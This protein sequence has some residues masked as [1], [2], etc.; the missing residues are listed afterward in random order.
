MTT[1][2]TLQATNELMRLQEDTLLLK[3]QLKQLD[4]QTQVVEREE[5]LHRMGS[6]TSYDD[7]SLIATQSLGKTTS[8][9]I[10]SSEGAE[11]SVQTGDILSNGMHVVSIRSGA[12]VLAGKGGRR[13]TLTV[14][15]PQRTVSSIAA[16]G[17]VNGGGVPPLPALPISMR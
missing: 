1:R 2:A 5:A 3:A 10:L 8:A 7:M 15:S 14:I 16:T 6:H 13:V 11:I 17:A 4:A 12:I 9:T